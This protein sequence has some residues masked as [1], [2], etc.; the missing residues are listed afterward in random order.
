MLKREECVNLSINVK[1]NVFGKRNWPS[2]ELKE[3]WNSKRDV[4]KKRMKDA[5]PPLLKW[6]ESVSLE[7]MEIFC[8]PITLKQPLDMATPVLS[9]MQYYKI[10][11]TELTKQLRPVLG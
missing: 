11:N 6:R 4:P 10:N 2:T 1:S 7:S 3:K 5:R 8:R 9:E